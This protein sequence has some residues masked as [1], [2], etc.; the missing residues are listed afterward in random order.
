LE[1]LAAQQAAQQSGL[2]AP[3]EYARQLGDAS[4]A[5]LLAES[6]SGQ[7]RRLA[8]LKA[9]LLASAR[10]AAHNAGDGTPNAAGDGTPQH[11]AD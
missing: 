4:M 5:E 11:D 1:A 3:D 2:L 8:A 6:R 7:A 9:E 10:A